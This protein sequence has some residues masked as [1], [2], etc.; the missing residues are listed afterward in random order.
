[1][2][3]IAC[4]VLLCFMSCGAFAADKY[5][6]FAELAAATAEGTDYRI[7]AINRKA[8]VTVFAIHG[9]EIEQGTDD[10]A[11]ACSGGDWNFYAFLA[12]SSASARDMHITATHF[13]EPA[14]V[15]FA[16]GAVIGLAMHGQDE[17]GDVVCVGGGND[18]LRKKIAAALASAGFETETPCKRLPG[19][20]AANIVNRARLGGVQFEFSQDILRKLETSQ[21]LRGRFCEIVRRETGGYL[22]KTD[23]RFVPA[24]VSVPHVGGGYF[25]RR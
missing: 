21:E 3:K 6:N 9:G 19:R 24:R 2:R 5:R 23:A 12:L 10:I 18:S 17:T 16:T 13:D 7:A 11:M 20:S 4:F 22:K 8:A 15:W 14:A 25:L 1:M